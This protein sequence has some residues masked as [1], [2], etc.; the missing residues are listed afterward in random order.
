MGYRCEKG[1]RMATIGLIPASGSASRLNGIPKFMLPISGSQT[2]IEWHTEQMLKTC[3][4]VIISTKKEWINVVKNLKFPSNVDFVE[5]EPSTMSD[6]INTMAKY[7]NSLY[8]VGMPDT[9]MPESNGE[10]YQKL[11]KSTADL[12]L[13]L[14]KCEKDLKGRVGQVDFDSQWNVIDV[15]D[16]DPLCKYKYMWGA[17]AFQ[18]ISID[19]KFSHPGIQVNPLIYSGA[20]VKCFK[21]NGKYIDAGTFGGLKELYKSC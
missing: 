4:G 6:A 3:E 9:Y 13:A 12:T 16:K 19:P 11:S 21:A 2:L 1:K 7:S 18:G 15:V 5:K 14:W 17:L 8:I 10:F 20:D